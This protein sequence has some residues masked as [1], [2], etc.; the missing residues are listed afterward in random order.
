MKGSASEFHLPPAPTSC[1]H[2]NSTPCLI[3]FIPTSVLPE[4]LC[5]LLVSLCRAALAAL[6]IS[7]SSAA[8]AGG[9]KLH[10]SG[11]PPFSW[12]QADGVSPGGVLPPP[13]QPATSAA[14]LVL[15]VKAVPGANALPHRS[16]CVAA[17]LLSG[18][19][20]LLGTLGMDDLGFLVSMF[21]C[22]LR[23]TC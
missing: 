13:A 7:G 19:E 20:G 18:A 15:V 16:T 17:E 4:F 3:F 8:P 14:E 6:H 23:A 10:A 22:S 5:Y 12:M 1:V 11:T 9:T 2:L 21:G